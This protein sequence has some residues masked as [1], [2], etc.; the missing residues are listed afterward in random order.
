MCGSATG[1]QTFATSLVVSLLRFSM[2]TKPHIMWENSVLLCTT[3]VWLNHVLWGK[4]KPSG[5]YKRPGISL[6]P[7][8]CK[9]VSLAFPS[10]L[11]PC[12]GQRKDP[13]HR[14]AAA[15]RS[16]RLLSPTQFLGAG[17]HT[18]PFSSAR[19]HRDQSWE[20]TLNAIVERGR[21][22]CEVD[23]ILSQDSTFNRP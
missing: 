11:E 23:T 14:A 10:N 2:H 4:K 18:L 8:T 5:N 21:E 7:G 6:L 17:S 22:G 16:A 13:P 9:S 12:G 19:P 20:N 1:S 15:A 3:E